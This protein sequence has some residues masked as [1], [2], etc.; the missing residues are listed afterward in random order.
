ME[1][2]VNIIIIIAIIVV[3]ILIVLFAYYN[4]NIPGRI[5][6]VLFAFAIPLFFRSFSLAVNRDKFQPKTWLI[7]CGIAVAIYSVVVAIVF[8]YIGSPT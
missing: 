7:L 4:G 2:A 5:E 3:C 6:W 1:K 8:H